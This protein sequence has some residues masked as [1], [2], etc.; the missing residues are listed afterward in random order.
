MTSLR[1]TKTVVERD[2]KGF[3][4]FN[5]VEKDIPKESDLGD[6]QVLIAIEAAPINPSDIGPL[7]APS[8]AAIG[9]FD[10]AVSSSD[11]AGRVVT[12]LPLPDRTFHVMKGSSTVGRATR[13]GN[14]GAGRV[15]GAGKGAYAQ[16]LKGKL[17]AAMGFG[18][19]Y[20]QH[21]VVNVA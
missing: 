5:I 8:H 3:V 17:V 1:V 9:R 16:S 20:G 18:G 21:A 6:D 13:V 2:G 7:F 19:S 14:E 4:E 12:A 15:I 10:G 11:V